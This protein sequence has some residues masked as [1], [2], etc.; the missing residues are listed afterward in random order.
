MRWQH[1]L[2]RSGKNVS[3]SNACHPPS[4]FQVTVVDATGSIWFGARIEAEHNLRHLTPVGALSG[5]VQQAKVSS[6]VVKV[7]VCHRGSRWRLFKKRLALGLTHC[8]PLSTMCKRVPFS[9][10]PE[11]RYI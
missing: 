4:T 7:V 1:H 5:R 10:S 6:A 11:R 9:R 2:R 8:G 3:V